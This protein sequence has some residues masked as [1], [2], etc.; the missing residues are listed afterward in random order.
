MKRLAMFVLL[1]FLLAGCGAQQTMET[2]ADEYLLP[3]ANTQRE[4]SLALPEEANVQVMKD[5]EGGALYLCDGYTL[6]VQT[7]SGGDLGRTLL[8]ATGFAKDELQVMSS[9][10]EDVKRYEA[11]WTAAGE[12]GPQIGRVCV[13][14]DGGYHYVLTA[15]TDATVAGQKQESLKQIF[16]SFA[17]VSTA[18]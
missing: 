10:Q 18:K 6:T 13:L 17:L 11:V 4:I 5:A 9:R 3:V 15:M 8:E 14:D 2:V 7:A 12:N 1:V 16:S